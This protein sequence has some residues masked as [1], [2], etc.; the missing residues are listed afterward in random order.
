MSLPYYLRDRIPIGPPV[1]GILATLPDIKNTIG[2]ITKRPPILLPYPYIESLV[3]SYLFAEHAVHHDNEGIIIWR[4]TIEIY[5][6]LV[7]LA[8]DLGKHNKMWQIYLNAM[9]HI[10]EGQQDLYHCDEEIESVKDRAVEVRFRTLMEKYHTLYEKNIK[11]SITI[12]IYCLDLISNHKDIN[13][14]SLAEYCEDDLSYKLKKI[15][16]CGNYRFINDLSFLLKGI[17]PHVKNAISHRRIEYGEESNIIFKNRD[18]KGNEWQREFK[19]V[20]FEKLIEAIQIN[21]LAQSATMMLFVYDY[22]DKLNFEGI[23]RFR[24][25]K[26]LRALIYGII[27]E[28]FFIS[29]DI[30]FVDDNS[31]I[32]CD[33][34]KTNGFDYPSE[35][36]GKLSGKLIRKKR[37]A[38]K[39]DEQA[40]RIAFDIAHLDTEFQEC[41]V[42][43]FD[44]KQKCGNIKVNLA[45]WTKIVQSEYTKE[46]LDKYIIE[47]AFV[48]SNTQ[49]K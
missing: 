36:I 14:K 21:F 10:V 38:L 13:E 39:A 31:K 7:K 2:H 34:Q 32:I 23:K 1:G 4:K 49:V 27:Q 25:L 8:A 22:Q 45:E 5:F 28:A 20:E 35:C 41:E 42:N 33:V 3:Q 47:N 40:L 9:K 29:K 19:L 18:R 24:N 26:Q 30:R 46:D 44:Y 43:V 16:A 6:E 17:E 12:A 37:P 11:Y 48:K 15:E